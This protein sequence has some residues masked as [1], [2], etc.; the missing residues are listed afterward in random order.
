MKRFICLAVACLV[1]VTGVFAAT[2]TVGEVPDVH[3]ADRDR[4]VANP[5]G[6]LSAEAV[7]AIDARLSALRSSTSVEPMVVAL[8]NISPAD[9]DLFATELF[10]LWGL[11]KK[12]KDNGLLILIV[13]DLRK[14]TIRPGYG[15]E[16]VLTDMTCGRIIRHLMAPEFREGD[17]S[18]GTLAAVDFISTVLSDPDNAA[19]YMSALPD[20]DS[21]GDGAADDG[22][23]FYLLCCAIG[24]VAMLLLL[25]VRLFEVRGKD[26]YNKYKALVGLKPI[27]LAMTF[28]GLGMPVI[29]S[30][31]L[32][33]LLAHWRNHRRVC[34]GC[35]EKMQK[36]DEVHDNDYLTPAQDLE[37][38]V[39]SVDYD[40]WLCPCC[41][42]T[43]ILAYINKSTPMIEC[44]NC[45]ALTARLRN[46][47]VIQKPTATR[48]GK[49]VREYECLNCHHITRRMRELPVDDSAAV[50]AA[51]G[52]A[53]MMGGRRGGGFGGGFGGGSI[54]GGFGG[55]ST[56][57]GGATG[58]W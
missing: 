53:A 49:S 1:I 51:L 38:R 46:E 29:A 5:D 16:G 20:A 50:A 34:P 28:L 27:Y 44:D 10:Q 26:D 35:G 11:G 3:R 17:Y 36:V 14:A 15:L 57:G 48:P 41:G 56:G 9:M 18:A 52:T 43:D 45:H 23:R 30:V 19:E 39:G 4:F 12:D 33:L 32:V 47:R 24:A 8:D 40:V 54:G 37:E 2:Y 55:G 31:P 7:A 42:E 6:I 21:E 13:K 58:G 22:F 25:L